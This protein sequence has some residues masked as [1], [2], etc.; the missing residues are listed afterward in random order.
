MIGIT[1]PLKVE[2]HAREKWLTMDW[3]RRHLAPLAIA[4]PDFHPDT[5]VHIFY[6]WAVLDAALYQRAPVDKRFGLL[7]ESSANREVPARSLSHIHRY[8]M[9]LTHDPFLLACHPGYQFNPHGMSWVYREGDLLKAPPK[10]EW[11]SMITSDLS[12]LPGHR[13]RLSIARKLHQ[14]GYP[15][16]IFG[17]N[18]PWG[19]FIQDKRE[20][21]AP[22]LFNIAVENCRKQNYF[23]EKLIDCFVTRTVPLY[24]G[25]PNIADF[26]NPAGMILFETEEE[27]WMRL[28][29]VLA[30]G[31]ALYQ[32]MTPALAENL[33]I[34]AAKYNVKQAWGSAAETIT[35]NI[36]AGYQH[37]RTTVGKRATLFCAQKAFLYQEHGLQRTVRSFVPDRFRE[38]IARY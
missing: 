32:Q 26:F 18:I 20:G 24:W 10:S 36:Q 19:P 2:V 33:Q 35:R 4:S 30:N 8:R 9:I 34:A 25:C 23:T 15:V 1:T 17:R 22:Y 5:D 38:S 14:G 13:L 28:G 37:H 11:M 3:Q 12:E 7:L 29:E 16:Q 21:L 31:Q 27:F 6:E